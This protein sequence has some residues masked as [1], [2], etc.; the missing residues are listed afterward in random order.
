M[1]STLNAGGCAIGMLADGLQKAAVAGKY[2]SG[3]R[4]KR[5][6]LVSPFHPDSRF[7]VGNA[8]GRN[9]YI[10][11]LS[12]FALIVSAEVE[13]GGTWTG[14]MEELKRGSK[15]VFVRV[16]AGAPDGNSALLNH[17]AREFPPPPWNNELK[18]LL[19]KVQSTNKR[20]S[21]PSQQ[22]LFGFQPE[23]AVQAAVKESRKPF[24]KVPED[25]SVPPDSA[26][27]T[28]VAEDNE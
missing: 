17:G 1:L 13:K 12:D 23:P 8:M 9:K 28:E 26:F 27:K 19:S 25:V 11:A 21:S 22:S 3:I 20:V 4:E 10:Y 24:L 6:V 14:A 5:L 16:D 7:N 15:S 18:N 2:R